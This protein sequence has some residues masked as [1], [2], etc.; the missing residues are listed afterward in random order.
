VNV[1]GEVL[2]HNYKGKQ[3]RK[4]QDR[5]LKRNEYVKFSSGEDNFP[6]FLLLSFSFPPFLLLSF[7]LFNFHNFPKPS[8]LHFFPFF[9]VY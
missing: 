7:I 6:P 9:F 2:L 3:G 8:L 1:L 5:L 4:E